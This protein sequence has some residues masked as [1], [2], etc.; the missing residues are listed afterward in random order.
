MPYWNWGRSYASV[1]M[2]GIAR[3]LGAT[4]DDFYVDDSG[5]LRNKAN[6]KLVHRMVCRAAH[7]PFNV[8]WHV[9]HIDGNKQNNRP[10]NLIAIPHQLHNKIHEVW[11]RHCLPKRSEI[12]SMLKNL[13]ACKGL[14]RKAR[15][16]KKTWHGYRLPAPKKVFVP[17]VILRK[18]ASG[19]SVSHELGFLSNAIQAP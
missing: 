9:H 13:K 4:M 15:K 2:Q 7:G 18:K 17:K 6:C 5:Y 11:P 10:E 8:N 16:Q 14:K 19:L 1:G 12:L 3:G